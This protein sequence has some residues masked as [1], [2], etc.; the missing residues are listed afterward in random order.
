MQAIYLLIAVA[1]IVD[2]SGHP[3]GPMNLAGVVPWT[4]GRALAVVAL[5][6]AGNFFCMA[7]PFTL[8][9]EPGVALGLR[10]ATLAALLR[11]KWLAVGLLVLFFWAYEA[12]DLWNSPLLTAWILVAYFVAAFAVD[13]LFRGAS[14]CKYVCPIG[15]FNFVSSLVSP[16]EVRVRRAGGLQPPARHTIA[17]A[18]TSGNAAASSSCFSLEKPG[19]WTARSA[20]TA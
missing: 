17:C 7:C 3:M 5:L 19:T 13:T 16:F 1:V 20:W 14:F 8:P 18:A 2:G 4:Y 10:H 6:A 9:R 12:F 11:T 15:Q